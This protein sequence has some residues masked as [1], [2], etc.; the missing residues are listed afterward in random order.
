MA[1]LVLLGGAGLMGRL[2]VRDWVELGAATDTLVVADRQGELVQHICGQYRERGRSLLPATVDV[3]DVKG[4]AALLQGADVV[5]N[6]TPYRLNL[7]VMEAA[8]LAQTHY[9]DLGG[10]FHVTRQQLAWQER[11]QAI[12][13]TALLGMGAA[14]GISNILARY[15]AEEL[16]GVREIHILVGHLDKTVYDPPPLFPVSYSLATILEELSAPPAI[17][18]EGEWRFLE[19]LAGG[20]AVVF[21]RPIGRQNPIYTLHSEVA[22]LPLSFAERG[23]QEVS[24][25]IALDP[26]LIERVTFLQRLGLTRTDPLPLPTGEVIPL[27]VLEGLLACQQPSVVQGAYDQYEVIRVVIK[28][29]Q[30]LTRKGQTKGLA[31][32]TVIADCHVPGVPE[33]GVGS[34]V[35]TG[36]PAMI[37]AEML[38]QGLITQR[39]VVV[40]EVAVPVQ[41]FLAALRQRHIT[42]KLTRQTGW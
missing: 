37:A 20:G 9:V 27:Q 22:T 30:H 12:G 4:T 33:W 2:A 8:W 26:L 41:P 13:K 7:Q 11:F 5:I 18:T 16:V 32:V 40:P 15:G 21:P 36:S 17:F 1:R 34:D 19:P 35:D 3:R 29:S 28:G 10:L 38:V 42:V 31:R 24:F 23:I 39:G 6:M 14:P 25:R